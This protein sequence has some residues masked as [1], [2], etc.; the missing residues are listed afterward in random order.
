[1]VF[2]SDNGELSSR[3]V[4]AS[5]FLAEW[6]G[7]VPEVAQVGGTWVHTWRVEE[8]KCKELINTLCNQ[9]DHGVLR[10]W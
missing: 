8:G 9:K 10:N 4:L 3:D 6:S 5:S 2:H 1:M 7:L